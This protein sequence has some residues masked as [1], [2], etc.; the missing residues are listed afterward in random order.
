MI[1]RV[2]PV[3]PF[4]YVV[5][6]GT[7]DLARRKLL[8]ALY[9]RLKD[10]QIPGGSRII[11]ASRREMSDDA[12]RVMIG[13]ALEQ[14]L[15]AADRDPAIIDRFLG[16]A[17]YVSVDASGN[18][19]WDRLAKALADGED[20]VR[21]FYLAVGPDLFD[22]ICE[23]IGRHGL[24]TPSTRVVIEKPVGTDLES[25]KAVYEA[26]GAVFQEDQIFRIDRYLGKETV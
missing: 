10:A 2:I 14:F 19:G 4:D 6:G 1:Q 8:P 18:S 12:Y 9:Y 26:V 5:F 7:G 3:P 11:G 21:A 13:A 17:T 25:A 20:K 16:M 22:G 23:R 15:P 24:V